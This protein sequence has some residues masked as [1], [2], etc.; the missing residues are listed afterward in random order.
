MGAAAL[1]DA[2]EVVAQA[3]R[4]EE[5]LAAIALLAGAAHAA[6]AVISANLL[7]MRYASRSSDT[8]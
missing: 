4:S 8:A 5:D 7:F 1:F 6:A 2:R 3:R